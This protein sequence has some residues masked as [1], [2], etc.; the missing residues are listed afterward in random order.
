MAWG[1]APVVKLLQKNLM[2]FKA[3]QANREE[4]IVQTDAMKKTLVF[5]RV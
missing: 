3:N 5:F 2:H 4:M 1:E